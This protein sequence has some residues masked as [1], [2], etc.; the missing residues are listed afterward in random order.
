MRRR[1]LIPLLVLPTTLLAGLVG[2]PT[3]AAGVDRQVVRDPADARL[4]P[5][6]LT[7]AGDPTDPPA[8]KIG[9]SDLTTRGSGS[10]VLRTD[11]G[12][13]GGVLVRQ[14]EPLSGVVYPVYP[15]TGDAPTGIWRVE[16]NGDVLTS[17]PVTLQPGRW[18]EAALG[19]ATLHDGDGWSG[20]IHEY[21]D[22]FGRGATWSAGLLTGS[23]LGS[24][25]VRLDTI[26][27]RHLTLDLEPRIWLSTKVTGAHGTDGAGVKYRHPFHVRV[28]AHRYDVASGTSHR[29]SG[30]RLVLMRR[31][32]GTGK[33]HDVRTVRTDEHG[34]AGLT[35]HS[36]RAAYWR[37]EWRRGSAPFVSDVAEQGSVAHA[38]L[39]S[40]NGTRCRIADADAH[41]PLCRRIKVAPGRVVLSG[42][43]VPTVSGWVG[44]EVHQGLPRHTHGPVADFYLDIRRDGTWR[45]VFQ[46]PT[47]GRF[48]V[49]TVYYENSSPRHAL[50]GEIDIPLTVR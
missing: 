2:S 5:V 46:T 15:V 41:P 33:W 3:D 21:V 1:L 29:I 38:T 10:G 31:W 50:S 24:D 7:C 17:D 47:R 30:A 32:A 20:S 34:A 49:A 12:T 11:E 19:D 22:Q 9:V 18:N 25:E 27:A 14:P 36:L 42:R 23:C 6:G 4:E 48:M 45:A 13:Y 35:G 39:P 16:T 43:I 44:G 26:G 28:L 37:A 40:V 8:L